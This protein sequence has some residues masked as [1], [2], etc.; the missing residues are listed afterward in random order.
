MPITRIWRN[1]NQQ[2]IST[3][4][5]IRTHSVLGNQYPEFSIWTDKKKNF[6]SKVTAALQQLTE[7]STEWKIAFF[8]HFHRQEK[9]GMRFY[10]ENT[11]WPVK[12]AVS[13]DVCFG[14]CPKT[15]LGNLSSVTLYISWDNIGVYPKT[16]SSSPRKFPKVPLVFTIPGGGISF[17]TLTHG[18]HKGWWVIYAFVNGRFLPRAIK[19]QFELFTRLSL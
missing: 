7:F 6:N 15:G 11:P 17:M 5:H 2:E 18:R 1:K 9:G 8:L 10:F 13:V 3:M 14:I 12:K 19:L 4:L 16:T